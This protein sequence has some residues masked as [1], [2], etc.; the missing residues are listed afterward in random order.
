MIETVKKIVA[1]AIMVDK[2]EVNECLIFREHGSWD[3]LAMLTLIASI[4][5]ELNIDVT[6]KE[7]KSIRSVGELVRFLEE[8]AK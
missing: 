6:D 4:S 8:R 2:A 1:A 7:M 3:S 5:D